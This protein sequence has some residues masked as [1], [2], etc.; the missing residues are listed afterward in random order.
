MARNKTDKIFDNSF[1]ESE[2]DGRSVNWKAD[3]SWA[4]SKDSESSIVDNILMERINTLVVESKYK[5]FNKPARDGKIPKLSK[6][7]IGVVYSY[8][9]ERIK[10]YNV[11]E[12]FAATSEYFDIQGAKFYN[13][14]SNAH[15][16]DLMVELDRRTGIID[17]KKIRKLF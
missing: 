5:K 17:K 16:D 2:Y 14:L 3:A 10:D 11:I 8:I 7:Q 12:I 4:E 13:S 1:E 15:K 6:I 9:V